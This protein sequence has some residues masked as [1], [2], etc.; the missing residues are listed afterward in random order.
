METENEFKNN[1]YEKENWEK[2]RNSFS[3]Y[4]SVRA[5][6]IGII[7]FIICTVSD[8]KNPLIIADAVT[9]SIVFCS[10]LI[11]CL[12][13][14]LG[15]SNLKERRETLLKKINYLARKKRYMEDGFK[16]DAEKVDS[17]AYKEI[18]L[19]EKQIW[20]LEVELDLMGE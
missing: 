3:Y 11:L 20:T 13:K 19:L 10:F 14:M 9:S 17:A 12:L 8:T 16:E 2:T 1:L 6:F 5:I 7:V 15:T 18:N 4:W